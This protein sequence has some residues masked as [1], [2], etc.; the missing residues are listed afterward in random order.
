MTGVHA[1]LF[2]SLE[3]EVNIIGRAR[4][5]DLRFDDSGISR[6]HTRVTRTRREHYLLEDLQS[7]N[8]TILNGAELTRPEVLE[9]GDRV[10]IGPSLVLQFGASDEAEEQLAHRL[11]EASTR[12]PLTRSYNRR[13][14]IERLE[15]ELSY[16][17][18]HES[19]LSVIVFDLD[20]FKQ[21]ND[22]HGHAA[23]DRVLRAVSDH[24]LE[25]IRKEDTFARYGGEEFAILVRGLT[26]EG[27]VRL[28]ERV[29][30]AIE[31]LPILIDSGE[32]GVTI[33]LGVAS[34]TECAGELSQAS[35]FALADK[36]LYLAKELGRN[37][38]CA[39]DPSFAASS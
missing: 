27:V 24:V 31:A 22:H 6:H 14:L 32:I 19:L 38:V 21:V 26:Q 29:R 15:A 18:R 3:K 33:S 8:G 36:R 1:G 13:Y 35:L 9:V 17:R 7:K 2:L 20:L 34:T 23:G 30:T 11:F 16:A 25:L 39:A 10:Q 4:D 12:D 37:Q 28:A 5:A